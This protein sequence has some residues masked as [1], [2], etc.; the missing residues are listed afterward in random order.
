MPNIKDQKLLYH[1]TE[2]DNIP[3]IL[4]TGLQPRSALTQFVDVADCDIIQDRQEYGLE[5]FVP[6]HWFAGNPFDGRVQIDHPRKTF[7]LIAVHRDVAAR[8]NWTVIPRHPLAGGGLTLLDYKAGIETID[9]EAMNRRDYRE[10]NSKSVCMA[11]CLS[12]SPVAPSKFF[13]IFVATENVALNVRQH[14]K[15]A[16]LHIEVKINHWM[17]H[18]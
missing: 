2:L 12:P 10:A 8:E 13:A 5:N 14:V 6:F 7:A 18:R 9:W 15:Q 17:F 11:E 3:S 16:K 1:L 4:T